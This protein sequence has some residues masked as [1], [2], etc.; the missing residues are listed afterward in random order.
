[1]HAAESE[2]VARAVKSR[3]QHRKDNTLEKTLMLPLLRS[4]GVR[5]RAGPL[6]AMLTLWCLDKGWGHAGNEEPFVF[7]AERAVIMKTA[8][9][10]APSLGG[11]DKEYL[12]LKILTAFVA[13]L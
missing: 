1:M 13:E 9:Q 3:A 5:K 8:C 2:G 11:R 12:R 4:C 7:W 10:R 6:E